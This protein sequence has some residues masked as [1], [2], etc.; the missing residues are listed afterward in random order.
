MYKT[1]KKIGLDGGAEAVGFAG[2]DRLT[3]KPSM[4]ASYLLPGARSII[5][6]MKPL[7]GQTIRDY[8]GKKNRENLQRHETEVY[9]LLHAIGQ[10][11]AT[12]LQTQGYR[13]VV[14]EPNL[15]YRYKDKP[16]YK[17]VPYSIR[18][19][20]ADW[21]ASD[22][23]IPVKWIKN[24]MV[25]TL[26]KPSFK[27]V[28]WNLTPSFSHRYGAIASGIGYMG[29]SGNVLHPAYGA[30]VLYNTVIT[31]AQLPSDPMI[32]ESPC[33]GCRICTRVCQSDFLHQKQA[34]TVTIGRKTFEHNKKAHNLRCI[35]V[36]AG[37]SGQ[38]KHKETLRHSGSRSSLKRWEVTIIIQRFSRI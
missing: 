5:S 31:D 36:C 10:E 33:D 20:I 24:A 27:H 34:T 17:R 2:V 21:F 1:I 8:L 6:V 18:Q 3:D 11:Q 7:D 26:S 25:P 12:Y 19:K 23:K 14:A 15:D 32:A 4:D 22:S 13:A 9:R 35:F 16:G 30:R 38:N 28:D 37:F 29:W